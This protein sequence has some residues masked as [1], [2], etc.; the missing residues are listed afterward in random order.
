M[1]LISSTIHL[2]IHMWT[3]PI[4]FQAYVLHCTSLTPSPPRS[5][6]V[7][8]SFLYDLRSDFAIFADFS[9]RSGNLEDG[10]DNFRRK[11]GNTSVKSSSN[12]LRGVIMP[13]FAP[14]NVVPTCVF[15]LA[16]D[17]QADFLGP[18]VTVGAFWLCTN[19]NVAKGA[20]FD[21]SS[22][23]RFPT[24]AQQ[25]WSPEIL[26]V[27]RLKSWSLWWSPQSLSATSWRK[28]SLAGW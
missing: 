3:F 6:D 5:A 9:C 17:F 14:H 7:V 24:R 4:L 13:R 21:Q 28:F 27:E 19:T 16:I 20:N 18:I 2:T 11:D 8:R 22:V 25:Y 15:S 26:F 1:L 23:V 12:T 10:V